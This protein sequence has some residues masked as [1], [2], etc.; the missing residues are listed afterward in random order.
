MLG[1][2]D[3]PGARAPSEVHTVHH[4]CV[5]GS[6]KPPQV[7]WLA[8]RIHRTQKSCF[9]HC[10]GLFQG[11]RL[12]I[13]KG[14][15]TGDPGGPRH[16]LLVILSQGHGAHSAQCS[17][18]QCVTTRPGN[19]SQGPSREPWCPGFLLGGQSHSHRC[20]HIWLTL[21][22][23]SSRGQADT[24][25]PQVNKTLLPSRIFQEVTSQEPGKINLWPHNS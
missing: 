8:R 25:C 16:K 9:T 10:Q 11:Y 2:H 17:Q 13:A 1:V 20:A 4:S 18:P 5:W 22:S 19:G 21:V 7:Q 6:P 12:K 3:L 15:G 23:R 24:A 14:R